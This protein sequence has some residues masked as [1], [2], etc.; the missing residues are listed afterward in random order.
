MAVA[1]ARLGVAAAAGEA[2]PARIVGAI[3]THPHLLAGTE[4][5]DSVLVAE[6]GGAL[7]AKIGAD[8]VHCVLAPAEGLGVA[9]KIED[10]SVRVQHA[11]LVAVLQAVGLL[12]TTLTG[13]LAG[14]ANEPVINTRGETVG[15]IRAA[16]PA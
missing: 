11:A 7:I 10:G 3:S 12:P 6:T 1:Y 14:F 5:F 8:G 13:P 2:A 4:R 15:W 16:D 9:L